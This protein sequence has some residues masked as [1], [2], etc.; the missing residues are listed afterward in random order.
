MIRKKLKINDGFSST[1]PWLRSEVRRMQKALAESGARVGADGFFG[2]KTQDAVKTFQ[3]NQGLDVTGVVEGET[4]KALEPFLE[5]V[6]GPLLALIK[7]LLKSFVGDLDWVHDQEGHIGRAYW[8]GGQSGVTLDPGVDLGYAD[9]DLV[10]KLYQPLLSDEQWQAVTQVF[11]TRAGEAREALG[12]D[13]VLRT[14]K[15]GRVQA[16]EILPHAAKPYWD[17]IAKRFA[18]LK[19]EDTLPAVQTVLLSLAYNRGPG[20]GALDVLK[21]PLEEQD[22][23][24]VA[25]IVGNMQQDHPLK[26]IRKRRQWESRL[27]R[28]ELA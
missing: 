8:P 22:W 6:H 27:I 7:K 12:D 24:E 16:E 9:P 17:R 26:G 11:G 10:E 15:M 5:K 21:Q 2:G 18:T 4:W 25:S 23:A 14:I 20:N 1:T 3:Q 13:P 19:Q 28:A